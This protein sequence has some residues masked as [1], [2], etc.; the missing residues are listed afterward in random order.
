MMTIFLNV[1][2]CDKDKVKT[3]GAKF[4]WEKRQWYISDG[5]N[6]KKFKNWFNLACYQCNVFLEDGFL[7]NEKKNRIIC[8]NCALLSAFNWTKK[9]INLLDSENILNFV[10]ELNYDFPNLKEIKLALMEIRKGY[11]YLN[12][13]IKYSFKE[14]DKKHY[15]KNIREIYQY[16]IKAE[17]IEQEWSKKTFHFLKPLCDFLLKYIKWLDDPKNNFCIDRMNTSL[18]SYGLSVLNS[19]KG[20]VIRNPFEIC[21]ALKNVPMYVERGFCGMCD[22]NV[23]N[24]W[25]LREKNINCLYELRHLVD[26]KLIS[27]IEL[28]IL[29]FSLEW[30]LLTENTFQTY[31]MSNTSRD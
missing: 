24:T 31:I 27:D 7:I 11:E 26:A 2:F 16:I 3:L 28:N 12:I 20:N 10:D 29:E 21:C 1:S 17:S 9:Y 19:L 25:S 23:T 14:E 30:N 13:I 6:I 5:Q 4:D 22:S 8:K 18:D 15:E